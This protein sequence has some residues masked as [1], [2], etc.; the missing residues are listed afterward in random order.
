MAKP[1]KFVNSVFENFDS[2]D[3]VCA[4]C[5]DAYDED[6]DGVLNYAECSKLISDSL[7]SKTYSLTEEHKERIF[8]LLDED[9]DG[10]ICQEDFRRCGYY[11]LKQTL[12]P[13]SAII[14][15]DVQN[16]FINGSLALQNC[17]A[18]HDGVEVVPVINHIL[19]TIPFDLV[20]YTKDW[21]P[22]N[23]ISFIENVKQRPITTSCKIKAEEAKV[24]D[25]VE[26]DGPPKTEQ[27][28]WPKHCVNGTWGS[29]LHPD[30][31]IVEGASYVNKGC[32]SE[33][34][35]YSAFWDN[36]KLTQTDLVRIL[37]KHKV[38]DVYVCGVA[39]DVCVGFTAFHSL[40][41]GFRTVLIDDACR[42]VDN[43]A[44]E[45]TKRKLMESGGIIVHSSKVKAIVTGEDRPSALGLQ[46]A[47]N[48]ALAR[49]LVNRGI[50]K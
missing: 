40:E 29:E 48:V 30:L 27:K 13:V 43:D 25:T 18:G 7:Q 9:K 33:V 47:K 35:S 4:E 19:D 6:R 22:D 41:H 36:N 14:I 42:G 10:L 20:V 34:D 8:S 2:T 16:D 37:A 31:K 38:T 21:H 32:H 45:E 50:V 28:L 23:H 5:F 11:W 1:K 3:D 26:F 49:E 46:T 44:I 39:Y 17:P 12:K 24:Y 15:I